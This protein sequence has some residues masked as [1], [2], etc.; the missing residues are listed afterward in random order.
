MQMTVTARPCSLAPP[1]SLSSLPA[2]SLPL[3]SSTARK[4]LHTL[5]SLSS[6]LTHARRLP[7]RG[8][9]RD[10]DS[11]VQCT[12]HCTCHTALPGR[13]GVSSLPPSLSIP[14][15]FPLN[16]FPLNPSLLPSLLSNPPPPPLPSQS[17]H[18]YVHVWVWL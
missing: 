5:D 7:L 12:W 18:V 10:S 9:N 11:Q 15:S 4:I 17:A 14:P 13:A 6:P 8:A 1:T 16:P 2:P 3:S